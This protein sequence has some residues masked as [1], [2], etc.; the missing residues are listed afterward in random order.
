MKDLFGTAHAPT[1][2]SPLAMLHACHGRIEAQCT[3]L[4]KLQEYLPLHGCDMQAQ[5]AIRAVLRYFDTAGQ[6]HHQDEEQDLF[7]LL[8]VS[9]SPEAIV[10]TDRLLDEH[11]AMETAWHN[12]R[13]C[14]LELAE[15]T[16]STLPSDLVDPFNTAYARHIQ[17]ENG[18]LLPL[19]QRLLTPEQLHALG[20]SMASRRNTAYP[21][22]KI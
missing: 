19:T 20:K 21:H 17:L 2:D 10:L 16:S 14:L 12:L 7:P 11:R 5:Q 4:A 15:G 18:E 13:P 22:E 9:G 3:T 6:H 1:F 8:R